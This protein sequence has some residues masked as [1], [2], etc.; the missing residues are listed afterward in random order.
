VIRDVT[1]NDLAYKPDI[2][3]ADEAAYSAYQEY[4]IE[5]IDEEMGRF[6]SAPDKEEYTVNV[7]YAPG[8]QELQAWVSDKNN[9]SIYGDIVVKAVVPAIV[10]VSFTAVYKYGQERIEEYMLQSATAAAVRDTAGTNGLAA[11]VLYEA[12]QEKLPAGAH[13]ENMLMKAELRL[14]DGTI[15]EVS[16]EFLKLNY[17]PYGTEKTIAFYCEPEDVAV[18][19]VFI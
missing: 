2:Y 7:A 9:I 17:P 5:F 11:S 6:Q 14:P 3:F 4:V 12:L 13:I 18:M 1:L 19:S 15:T 16:K 8:I 10:S